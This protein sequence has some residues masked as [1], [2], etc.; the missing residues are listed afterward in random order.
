[1]AL[2]FPSLM[3]TTAVRLSAL[4]ILLFGLV[5]VILA[6]YMMRLS[7][8][9]LS[10]QTLHSLTEEVANIEM[11]YQRGGI[12]LALRT[13]DRRSRQPGAFLYLIADEQGRLLAGNV[14][15]IGTDLLSNTG[16]QGR[17]VLYSRLEEGSDARQHKALV[18]VIDL[19]NQMK[20]MVGRDMGDPE[21]FVEV[22]RKAFIMAFAAMVFGAI[23]IWL[24]IGRRAL[25]RID[26]ITKA[27]KRLMGGDLSGRL[28]E[29]GGADEFDRLTHNLNI[30]LERIEQLN[31]GLREVSDNIAHDLR[32]PLTRLRARAEAAL[33]PQNGEQATMAHYRAVLE[34]IIAESEQ[35]INTFNALLMISRI[36]AGI[37]PENLSR[38]NIRTI[39][40]EAVEFYA[41]VAEDANIKLILG[42]TCDGELFLNR[43]LVAQSLFNLIDNALKYAPCDQKTTQ[44]SVAI[45]T[46][47]DTVQVMIADNGEGIPAQERE[48]VLKRFYRMEKSRSKPGSGIGLSLAAAVMKLHGGQLVLEDNS[49]SGLRCVLVFPLS[50]SN[51]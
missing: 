6:L 17:A 27:S 51:R 32:T 11:S 49:P 12:A 15:S 18:L 38:H 14:R 47:Q 43:E 35:L 26:M 21:A 45:C 4:Y 19:P 44:V 5:A 36:E 50:G 24:L 20:L 30:M 23:L 10:E 33:R 9:M 41:P 1:M 37:Q 42:E 46:R 13:I 31:S 40:E 29:S 8:A 2:R 34:E 25:Q 7:V 16:G 39:V 3:R 28:P 22:I 48:K